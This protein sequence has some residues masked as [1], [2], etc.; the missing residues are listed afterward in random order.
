MIIHNFVGYN[1]TPMTIFYT[2]THLLWTSK[3]L[4]TQVANKQDGHAEK[5]CLSLTV[6]EAKTKKESTK[7]WNKRRFCR[8]F[9]SSM[10]SLCEGIFGKSNNPITTTKRMPKDWFCFLGQT[11]RKSFKQFIGRYSYMQGTE[12]EREREEGRRRGGRED[13][14]GITSDTSQKKTTEWA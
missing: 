9:W 2:R 11:N 12:R 14:I 1:P 5:L 13:S 10:M 3:S 4:R 6:W 8:L 7:H